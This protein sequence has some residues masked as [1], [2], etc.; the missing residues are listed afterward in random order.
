MGAKIPFMPREIGVPKY[1]VDGIVQATNEHLAAYPSSN[2]TVRE[3]YYRLVARG[4]VPNNL[5]A[6]KAVMRILVRAREA[7]IVDENRIEDPERESVGGDWGFSDV[8][9][10]IAHK[11]TQ[12]G[13]LWEDYTRPIWDTQPH[14]VEIWL[15]KR[16]LK[17]PLVEA[18]E[19][20]RVRI[21]VARGYS[22]FTFIRNA[23][24]RA[25]GV[26]PMIMLHVG[27]FDPSGVDMTRDLEERMTRYGAQ[28]LTV[29]RIA[30]TENQVV[31]LKLPPQPVKATDCRSKAFKQK[32]GDLVW[33][34][35]ALPREEL[36]KIVRDAVESKIVNPDAWNERHRDI[37]DDVS[38]L[39][40]WNNRLVESMGDME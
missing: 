8:D 12:I 25:S 26:R 3:I 16:A 19:G 36:Q 32:H 29:E 13:R 22:S 28:Q 10:F 15:E 30:L 21:N 20:L 6:Y 7:G 11:R 40:D 38:R 4:I 17:T 27:D 2:F 31:L 35:E 18:L 37:E 9:D 1:D 34:L 23:A 33:E 14:D 5:N 24:D 39:R